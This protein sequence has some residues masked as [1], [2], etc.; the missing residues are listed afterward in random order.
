MI[1][2][3]ESFINRSKRSQEEKSRGQG[4]L[5]AALSGEADLSALT[6]PNYINGTD[7]EFP[8]REMQ[9]M[10]YQLLGLFVNNHPM[11]GVDELVKCIADQ[12]LKDLDDKNDGAKI[13]VAVLITDFVRKLTKKK[14]NICIL[15]VEDMESRMEA[16]LFSRQLE[17]CEAFVEKGKRVLITGTLSKHSE[18]DQS[19]MIE[20]LEDID[21]M[22]VLEFD[23][24]ISRLGDYFQFL[25]SLRSYAI[26]PMNQGNKII[27]L[28]M[29][30]GNERR[31][32]SLGAKHTIND[33]D[34]T[35]NGLKT[36]IAEAS[37]VLTTAS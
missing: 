3:L 31:K 35:V 5:F 25:H 17:Q 12:T 2:N 23:L 27:V 16:V 34:A 29:I 9:E 11:Q 36:M 20:S 32:I 10:E 30:N 6:S 13:K 22:G 14:K 4:N 18:G 21:T 19:I 26:K 24:D 28:N 33:F 15:N 7:D 37:G 8:E 1:D